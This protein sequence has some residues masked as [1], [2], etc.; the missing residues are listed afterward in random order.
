M[1]ARKEVTVAVI[2]GLFLAVL[3]TGGILRARTAINT[4]QKNNP[5][6][7][8]GNKS[9]NH[10]S[11]QEGGLFLDIETQDNSVT[12]EEGLTIIGK[13]LPKT[14]IAITGEKG[15]YLIVP[16]EVGSFSQEITLVKG[17]NTIKVTVYQDDGKRVEKTLNAVY[18]TAEI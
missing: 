5:A 6:N 8:L 2:I 13:T 9:G 10:S 11:N 12:A 3:I 1:K 7:T 14:Y 4:M 18:T 16:N 17:A 15:E